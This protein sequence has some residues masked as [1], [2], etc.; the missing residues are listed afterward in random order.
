MY[1]AGKTGRRNGIVAPP[2]L[3]LNFKSQTH[4]F[5]HHPRHHESIRNC[6]PYIVPEERNSSFA[7]A[8][9]FECISYLL[10]R[11]CPTPRALPHRGLRSFLFLSEPPS[12]CK[13]R[14]ALRLPS[15]VVPPACLTA[16]QAAI[17]SRLLGTSAIRSSAG[18]SDCTR[19]CSSS[20]R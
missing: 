15:L 18:C 14:A 19:A 12:K 17:L 20:V 4:G 9:R 16:D 7:P 3:T 13:E 5:H 11:G 6:A 1:L 2:G 8:P 10:I